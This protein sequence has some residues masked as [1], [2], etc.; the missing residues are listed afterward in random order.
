MDLVNGSVRSAYTKQFAA[1]FGSSL[2]SSVYT[3]VDAAVV[4]L[5]HGPAGSAV[6][7]VFAPVWNVVY[8]FGLLA[9]VGGSV[10]FSAARGEG[11]E[12]ESNEYFTVS[13][14]LGILLSILAAATLI[15]FAEPLFRFFGA[16]DE[17]L[18]LAQE[19]FRPIKFSMLCS[20]MSQFLAAFLRND[21]NPKLAT[22]AV[23]FGGFFNLFGDW[24]FVFVRDLGI[25]GAA[26]ATAMGSTFTLLLMLTHFLTKKNTLRLVKPTNLLYKLRRVFAVGF[27]TGITDIAMGV[28]TILFNRQI[29]H[30]LGADALSVYAI[31]VNI[32]T[33]VQCCAYSVGQAAQPIFSVNFGARKPERIRE[34]FRYVLLTAVAFGV[35]WTLLAMLLPNFFVRAFM[36]PTENVLAIAPHIIRTYGISFL[37]LPLN[38]FSTFYFQALLQKGVS[39][40]ISLA[41]GCFLS[42]AAIVLLPVLLGGDAVWLAMPLTELLVAVYVF[43]KLKESTLAAI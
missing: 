7:A 21:S 38:V 2:I 8:S 10:L 34:C 39:L 30:Y 18:I 27:P 28:M 15:P 1:A 26:I 41:R 40:V 11:K 14:L 6:L 43:K 29:M 36:T 32:S 20:L 33:F 4:G 12:R 9:G 19:Y 17:L 25:Y 31:I 35:L 5:Y 23:F 13:F 37:L 16:D 24:Y 22:R 3:I 42:G